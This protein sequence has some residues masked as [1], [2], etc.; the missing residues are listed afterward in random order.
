MTRQI[1]SFGKIIFVKGKKKAL[2][3]EGFFLNNTLD[4]VDNFFHI[5]TK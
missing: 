2:K 1:M 5:P 3:N 4:H